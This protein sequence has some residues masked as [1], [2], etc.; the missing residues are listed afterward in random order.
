MG[1]MD[2]MI[3]IYWYVF[4]WIYFGYNS[5]YT[6]ME[7][8]TSYYVQAQLGQS[9]NLDEV[10]QTDQIANRRVQWYKIADIFPVVMNQKQNQA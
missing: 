10:M 3:W 4:V 7:Y 1:G 9:S 6:E 2:I 5:E 8:T